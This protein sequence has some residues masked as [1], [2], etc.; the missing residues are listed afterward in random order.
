[1]ERRRAVVFGPLPV[2]DA[3]PLVLL[4]DGAAAEAPPAASS[5]LFVHS[6]TR[7]G[8]LH[9]AFGYFLL[10]TLPA[11]LPA[12]T[13]LGVALLGRTLYLVGDSGDDPSVGTHEF[14]WWNLGWLV[15]C[16]EDARVGYVEHDRESDESTLHTVSTLALPV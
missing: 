12:L 9:E 10:R 14:L 4:L 11:L 1:V 2:V 5:I 16:S 7:E 8:P 13:L 6:R 3:S 15:F